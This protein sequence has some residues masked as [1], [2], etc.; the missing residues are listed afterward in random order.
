MHLAAPDADGSHAVRRSSAPTSPTSASVVGH[1][2]RPGRGGRR[3]RHRADARGPRACRLHTGD[4][5]VRIGG[6]S[7]LLPDVRPASCGVRGVQRGP[8]AASE[9]QGAR[10][11]SPASEGSSIMFNFLTD[12]GVASRLAATAVLAAPGA[13]EPLARRGVAAPGRSSSTSRGCRRADG[14]A[15]PAAQPNVI[16]DALDTPP[17]AEPLIRPGVSG[18][19]RRQAPAAGLQ[20]RP[21]E[22]CSPASCRCWHHLIYAYLLENTGVFEIFAEVVRRADARRDARDPGP[23]GRPVAASDRG[24]VLP[25]SAA[26]LGRLASPASCVPTTRVVRRNAYWRMFGMD[27]SHPIPPRWGRPLGHAAVEAG[28]RQRRQHDV[29]REVVGAAAPGLARLREPQELVGAN[30]TDDAYLLLLCDALRDMLNMRR[31]G[32]AA[33]ARGVRE[34]SR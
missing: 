25:R 29:P 26:V 31:R 7:L 17:A 18:I 3:G 2:R 23:A 15:V 22:A 21:A 12:L 5:E 1:S 14:T 30:A 9:H 24:A 32:A 33:G 19:N 11:P 10:R 20:P 8:A 16:G 28:R 6:T 4:R 27:L 13:V 34:P